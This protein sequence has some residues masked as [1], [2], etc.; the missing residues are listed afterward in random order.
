MVAVVFT[1][2][3]DKAQIALDTEN[4]AGVE[5][6]PGHHSVVRLFN[7]VTVQGPSGRTEVRD[8]PITESPFEAAIL[9]NNAHAEVLAKTAINLDMHGIR[10][11]DK[12]GTGDY[13]HQHLRH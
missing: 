7:A 3:W 1:K 12:T 13:G 6:L 2:E 8:V 9:Q 4:I 5:A 11:F 10:I